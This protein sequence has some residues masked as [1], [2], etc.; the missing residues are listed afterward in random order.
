MSKRTKVPYVTAVE[1]SLQKSNPPTLRVVARAQVPTG[2]W[3]AQALENARIADRVLHYDFVAEKPSTAATQAL[4]DLQA[5][6]SYSGPDPIIAVE[7]HGGLTSIRTPLVF[8]AAASVLDAT[9]R[10]GDVPVPFAAALG[11]ADIG[12]LIGKRLRVLG[13]SAETGDTGYDP[14]RATIFVDA[15][16]VIESIRFG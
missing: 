11:G 13:H 2:A 12:T 15:S 14:D 16:G 5:D 3:L 1:L 7:V 9:A 10:D 4:V 6:T 8:G